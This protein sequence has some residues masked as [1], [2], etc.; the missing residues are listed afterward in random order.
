MA[1]EYDIANLYRLA[2][3]YVAPPFPY[4]G[5]PDPAN[6]IPERA[7]LLGGRA[8]NRDAVRMATQL[9]V[10]RQGNGALVASV[11]EFPNEPI[12]SIK[13]GKEVV[14][15][16]LYGIGNRKGTVKEIMMNRDFEITIQGIL[17]NLDA[18]D[19]ADQDM[20]RLLEV[21]TF[22]GAIGVKNQLFQAA[23]ISSAVVEDYDFRREEGEGVR[24]Q[25]YSITLSSDQDFE[26]EIL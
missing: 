2:F 7:Y 10:Q 15:S 18:D 9:E 25:R 11:Y 20:R 13:G 24:Y 6:L 5:I 16:N 21:L 3:S 26:L 12:C 1:K 17:V 8:Q 22:D 23:G 14:K 19:Y 4:G